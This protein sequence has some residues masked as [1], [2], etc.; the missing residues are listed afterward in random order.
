MTKEKRMLECADEILETIKPSAAKAV[1]G[2]FSN[3]YIKKK[4]TCS[5]WSC[6]LV[7]NERK[8]ERLFIYR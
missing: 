3:V 7:T 8:K 4:L 2:M 5:V 6:A 1:L